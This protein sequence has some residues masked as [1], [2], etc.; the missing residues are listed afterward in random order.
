MQIATDK[1]PE[2]REGLLEIISILLAK[3]E[4]QSAI[5]HRLE[6][7]NEQLSSMLRL[8]EEQLKLL[9]HKRFGKSS[10][11]TVPEQRRLFNEAEM[12]AADEPVKESAE[13]EIQTITYERKNAGRK[14]LP[15][16]L[17]RERIEYELPEQEQSCPA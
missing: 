9:R 4:E 3:N 6:T 16:D 5:I 10:E 17:P 2:S 11:R 15:S 8:F 12:I 14:P 7:L 13:S 1:L